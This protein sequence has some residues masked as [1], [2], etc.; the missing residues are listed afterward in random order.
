[1]QEHT[2]KPGLSH[3]KAGNYGAV[4]HAFLEEPLME[5]EGRL[6]FCHQSES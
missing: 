4:F 2:K 3:N 1:M 5:I 6:V